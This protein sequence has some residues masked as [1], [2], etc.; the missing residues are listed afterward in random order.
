MFKYVANLS[1]FKTDDIKVIA[2]SKAN[3]ANFAPCFL[4]M[5]WIFLFSVGANAQGMMS[6]SCPMCGIMGWI[7]MTLGGL[8]TLAAIAALVSLTIFLIRRSSHGQAS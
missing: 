1:K 3:N 7:G 4:L 6:G 2:L 8:L 5:A